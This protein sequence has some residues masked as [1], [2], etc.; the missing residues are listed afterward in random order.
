VVINSL[1]YSE[2]SVG[3]QTVE[4][5]DELV[6]ASAYEGEPLPYVAGP[7][8]GRRSCGTGVAAAIS[9]RRCPA[10][11]SVRMPH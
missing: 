11:T 4:E 1:I 5:L 7:L 10:S 9:D 6:P 2:V 8:P 3:C